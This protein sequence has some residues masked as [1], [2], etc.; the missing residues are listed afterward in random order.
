M[1]PPVSISSLP[2]AR[3]KISHLQL[4]QDFWIFLEKHLRR[5]VAWKGGASFFCPRRNRLRFQ[6]PENK[7]ENLDGGFSPF[8]KYQSNWK[9]S[10]SK[11]ETQKYLKPPTRNISPIKHGDFSMSCSFS[12]GAWGQVKNQSEFLMVLTLWGTSPYPT[13]R[14]VRK[15]I[16]SKVP[17]GGG[18]LVTRR[19]GIC[20][21][22][23]FQNPPNTC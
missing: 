16:D 17:L 22:L 18:M 4:W 8:E 21:T 15:I 12:G 11:G 6:T 10:P 1:K 23:V 3:F 7:L 5:D 19:G 9:S 2:F 14:E 13:K 20:Y